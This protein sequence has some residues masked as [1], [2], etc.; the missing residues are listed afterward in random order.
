[1]ALTAFILELVALW[2]Q[3]VMLLQPCVMC[4]YERCALLGIMGAGIVGAIAPKTPLRYVAL[5]IWLY[6]ALRGLQLAWEHTMIQLHPSP[7]QTCDFAARFPTWLPL[8]KWW[9]VGI[10]AAYLIVALLV[11]I[12]QPFK[13]KKRDLFGR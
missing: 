8:D 3:H 9:L 7:F 10:F 6:S 1:M 12:A 13:P 11:L 4:I 5:V 2:F